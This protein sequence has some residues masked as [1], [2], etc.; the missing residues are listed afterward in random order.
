M[1]TK[2]KKWMNKNVT[3]S[4][5]GVPWASTMKRT[6][7]TPHCGSIS[8][9]HNVAQ[10]KP[11]MKIICC[12]MLFLESLQTSKINLLFLWE[13]ETWLWVIRV[14]EGHLGCHV[15]CLDLGSVLQNVHLVMFNLP[16]LC[17]L[18]DCVHTHK[19]FLASR[20]RKRKVSR[21][22]ALHARVVNGEGPWLVGGQDE[23]AN[24][25]GNM[26]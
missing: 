8:N 17:F 16:C 6:A 2:S 1:L 14:W 15:L 21:T 23:V 25:T 19:G 18:S 26:V 9:K 22:P 3:L 24:C 7:Y 11:D 5:K 20:E 13:G 12:M 4:Y 10:N